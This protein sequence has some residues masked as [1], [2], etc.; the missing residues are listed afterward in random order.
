[1][2]S[3]G[4][5]RNSTAVFPSS[6]LRP[7]AAVFVP[8]GVPAVA[9]KTVESIPLGDVGRGDQKTRQIRNRRSNRQQRNQTK[10]MKKS[11][12]ERNGRGR[13]DID[14]LSCQPDP[15]ILNTHNNDHNPGC[16]ERNSNNSDRS[17]R[18]KKCNRKYRH[19]NQNPNEGS[20]PKSENNSVMGCTSLPGKECCN[21]CQARRDKSRN[22]DDGK[23]SE[24][25]LE[26]T[27]LL[28]FPALTEDPTPSS[29]LECQKL[30]PTIWNIVTGVREL[31]EGQIQEALED[32][33]TEK[34]QN[35]LDRLTFGNAIPIHAGH[36]RQEF[37][38]WGE[39]ENPEDAYKESHESVSIGDSAVGCPSHVTQTKN[40]V[41]GSD[42]RTF[43]INRLRDRW[44]TAVADRQHRLYQQRIDELEQRQADTGHEIIRDAADEIIRIDCDTVDME[45]RS[46]GSSR[47]NGQSDESTSSALQAKVQNVVPL[48]RGTANNIKFLDLIV[49]QNDDQAL[50]EMIELAWST[51]NNNESHRNHAI[52]GQN[53]GH[54]DANRMPSFEALRE[55]KVEENGINLVEYGI[56]ILIRRNYPKLLRTIL[57]ITR[58]NVPIDSKPLIEAARLGREECASILLSKQEKGSTMLFLE[59]TDGNTALHYCCRENGNKD[60]L[61]TLLKQV[62]GNTKRKR[63][64][65]SKLVTARNTNLQTPLHVACEAGRNDLVEVFLTT[66]KSSLLFKVVSLEDFNHETPLLCAV[67]NYSYDVV[68]C[69]LM[70]RRNHDRQRKTQSQQYSAR[71]SLYAKNENNTIQGSQLNKAKNTACPLVWAAKSGNLE[72]IDLLIQFGDQSGTNYQV[73]DSLLTLLRA[74]VPGEA[75][76]KGSNSLILA[77]GNPFQEVSRP[78]LIDREKETSISVA[79]KMASD[80]IIRSII[81]TALQLVDKRQLARR[82][83]P[84]LQHRPEAFFKMLESKEDY[85]ANKAISNALIE[86]LLRAHSNRKQ[87]EFSKAIVLYEKI[88]RVGDEY[89][90]RLQNSLRSEKMTASIHHSGSWCFVATYTHATSS[91]TS[92]GSELSCPRYDRSAF[93]EKSLSLINL[94]WARDGVSTTE[95]FCPWMSR[96]AKEG[97]SPRA[98]LPNDVLTLIA[99]DGSR[100]PV[101][102]PTVS[103]KSGKLASALRFVR[104][105]C[106]EDSIDESINLELGIA[107]DFCKLLIQHMYHG[108]IC[109]GWPNLEDSEICRYLLELII[110][111]EEFL[112]PSLVQEIE[113]RLVSSTPMKCFCW[114]C[115]QALRCLPS[116]DGKT[117]AQCLFS[118]SGSSR[119]VNRETAMD[120][121]SL[122]N[123]IGGLDYKIF[124]VPV[125][126]ALWV[127]PEET[128]K[129]YDREVTEQKSWKINQALACLRN[130]AILTILKE[131]DHVVSCPNF[132]LPTESERRKD[133]QKQ[134]LLQICLDELQSN[135]A[136]SLACSLHHD[137][138]VGPNRKD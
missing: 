94:P 38:S 66:C 79:T 125:A 15:S 63:Q 9:T 45:Q 101:H 83:N 24:D 41:I 33:E 85:E 65:L 113:M 1:M 111:A 44:W 23:V 124:M 89:L 121:L 105:K 97:H 39:N 55:D 28:V 131:F 52:M 103:G 22:D 31:R 58:G 99:N 126:L 93:A 98:L 50:R 104:M 62:L 70:W 123:Y 12:R 81:S 114:D 46:I 78:G 30:Q 87:S 27:S 6:A 116:K 36:R 71:N 86:S 88:E 26:L 47:S 136:I 68:I 3:I 29:S 84:V 72:M 14:K 21:E 118:I 73:T 112:I 64:Q 69:L 129:N 108:S 110:V 90:V 135:S 17:R 5:L 37:P 53:N 13:Q 57:S 10:N 127:V 49:K 128:W 51:E 42:K 4:G 19:R 25:A 106:D 137:K 60:I 102:A 74:D 91:V 18:S 34:W 7:G 43:N 20:K 2:P 107:P 109:F 80:D 119:L 61:L 32:Q 138:L 54:F 16:N 56:T 100:F 133:S 35:G 67:S 115:C 120:V 122:T 82:R 76:L 96:N 95:C 48:H 117:E 75:K 59:D 130:I 92:G 77:G 40:G 132:F 11:Q 8:S 134:I